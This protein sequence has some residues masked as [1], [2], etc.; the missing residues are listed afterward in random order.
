MLDI[1]EEPPFLVHVQEMAGRFTDGLAIL[2][3]KLPQLLV[4]VRQRGL[5]MGL[6]LAHNTAGVLMS[7]AGFRAGLLLVYAN[8]DPSAV[9]L[10]PPLIISAAEV[11]LVL[12][13]LDQAQAW[14]SEMLGVRTPGSV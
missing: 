8:N 3:H 5:M 9:Q 4:E 13:R 11:D 2:Q 10:L 6:K 12:E 7:Q 1:L 14:T